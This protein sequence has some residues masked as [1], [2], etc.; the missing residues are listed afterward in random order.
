M[1]Y[2]MWIY[3]YIYL[4]ASHEIYITLILCLAGSSLGIT[5]VLEPIDPNSG[6]PGG[7]GRNHTDLV[8]IMVSLAWWL[9]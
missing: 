8:T 7:Q 4:Y 1:G 9:C 2:S 6:P 3:L 5:R